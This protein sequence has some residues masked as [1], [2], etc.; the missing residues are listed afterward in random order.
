V[1]IAANA[2]IMLPMGNMSVGV[3]GL[4]PGSDKPLPVPGMVF[5]FAMSLAVRRFRRKDGADK[6]NVPGISRSLVNKM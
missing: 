3:P 5:C 2:Y 4:Q 1:V 6:E